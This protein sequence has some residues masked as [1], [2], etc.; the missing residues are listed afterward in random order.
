[1]NW[2]QEAYLKAFDFAS[3]WHLGQTVPGSNLPYNVHLAKVSMEVIA[4]LQADP[5]LKGDLAVQCAILHD[6]LEDTAVD[7]ELLQRHFGEEVA[8]GV[9]A[10]T[11][12]DN[13]A[14]EEKME[15]SLM[16][17]LEQPKEI[18]L[19]KLA[20]RI[21]NL[22]PPPAFWSSEKRAAYLDEAKVIFEALHFASPFLARRFQEKM[23]TYKTCI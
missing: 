19:V 10:L 11:K 15:D 4:A 18:A 13:L 12:D 17:I 16:R 3:E 20:D 2:S 23:E 22:A 21:T 9:A 5:S 14:K 1:M 6:C 7:Y 8:D